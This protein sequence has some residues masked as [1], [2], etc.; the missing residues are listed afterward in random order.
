MPLHAASES[1]RSRLTLLSV[2]LSALLAFEVVLFLTPSLTNHVLG[3]LTGSARHE[4]DE[5]KDASNGTS[6][7]ALFI[8]E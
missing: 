5:R 7:S 1:V 4:R 3:A 6:G 2:W 8:P